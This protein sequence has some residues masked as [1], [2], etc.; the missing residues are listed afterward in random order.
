MNAFSFVGIHFQLNYNQV[1]SE[2]LKMQNEVQKTVKQCIFISIIRLRLEHAL[3]ITMYNKLCL[4]HTFFM[5]DTIFS[6][7]PSS[8]CL[9]HAQDVSVVKPTV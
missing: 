4:Q 9:F 2:I 6:A 5:P 7:K 8:G 3:H 1:V